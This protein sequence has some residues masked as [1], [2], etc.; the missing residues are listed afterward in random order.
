MVGLWFKTAFTVITCL[1]EE[2]KASVVYSICRM[3]PCIMYFSVLLTGQNIM[4]SW[5]NIRKELESL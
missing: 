4:K 2:R 5:Q 3:V 1:G